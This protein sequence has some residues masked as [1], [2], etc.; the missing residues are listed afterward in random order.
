VPVYHVLLVCMLDLLMFVIGIW[1]EKPVAGW[2]AN[3]F[4][5]TQ[6]DFDALWN[7]DHSYM[8]DM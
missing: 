7:R 8:S 3:G 4:C 1:L 5:P 6:L 2:H